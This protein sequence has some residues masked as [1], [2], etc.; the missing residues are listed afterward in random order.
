MSDIIQLLPDSVANQ[1]AA[2][3][4]IQRPASV[5]K[6]LIENATDAGT[7]NIIVNIT[8]AGRTLIQVIDNGKGMSET[9][10]RM[11]FERHATSKIREAK[12]LFAIN[13]MGF[14]GEALA[15]IAAVADVELKTK[16]EGSDLGTFIHIKGSEI[17]KQETVSVS[18]GSNFSVRNLFFNIPARRKFL[19][20]DNT[21]F[22]HIVSEFKKVALARPDI[23]LSLI[24]NDNIIYKLSSGKLIHRI[25]ELFGKTIS[26][27][28]IPVE[29][30]TSILKISGYI[31]KPE[32]AKKRNEEQY[33]F[34]NM[35]FMKHPYFYKAISLAYEQIIKPD[36]HPS[37]FLYFE[38]DPAKIDIN[39]HPAKIQINF[40]DSTGIFQLLRASI[41]KAL[42]SFNIVP[43]IDFDRDG[44]I[45]MPYSGNEKDD[46][47][48]PAITNSG[49]YNPFNEKGREAKMSFT[50]SSF[51]KEPVPENWD[52]L[53]NSFESSLNNET[54][55]PEQNTISAEAQAFS[56]LFQVKNKYIATPVK[57]G[58]ML[59]HITRAHER[60]LFESLLS[61]MQS[62]NV[63]IQKILYP[64]KIQL[65]SEDFEFLK[66]AEKSL[67]S[68]GFDI[69][70]N[71]NEEVVISGVP[72]HIKNANPKELLEV[73]LVQIKDD[74]NFLSESIQENL[75]ELLAKKASLSF[76]KPLASE[77]ML[78]IINNLFSCRMP[79]FTNNGRKII[80]IIKFD[81]IEKL[82]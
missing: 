64:V 2:G 18:I 1:I 61:S 66:S 34:V 26:K 33:F 57:S 75:S 16:Q 36:I 30:N 41:K 48:I 73:V 6:E 79:N 69:S 5:I 15:S 29:S 44:Y 77:E 32:I 3:E 72:S 67:K 62:G 82:F 12:D 52:L 42:G 46:L 55:T 60:I 23:S 13:S 27:N 71:K 10:A 24:H 49:N 22:R 4:V 31:G 25:S 80:E 81:E 51:K 56:K 47:K 20:A 37:F 9:D 76:A 59:I 68:I 28:L 45:E 70:F 65:T 78:H 14:R 43:S 63:S 39:I 11:A 7:N 8:D 54:K 53:Y 17:I 21:E 50:G 40:D 19:K 35:R 74:T 58:I 38:I